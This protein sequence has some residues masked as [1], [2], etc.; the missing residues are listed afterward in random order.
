MNSYRYFSVNVAADA[1]AEV[2]I[3]HPPMNSLNYEVYHELSLLLEELESDPA[4]GAV[5]FGSNHPK[6][7]I[8]GA[9]IKD[10]EGYDRRS[11]AVSRKVD[12]VQ[13]VFQRLQRFPKPTVAAITGHALGG[14]CEFSLCVDF[15]VM[16]EGPARIGQPEVALGII[17]GGGGTQRL[18]R[19]IGRA[20]ATE[21]LMLSSRLS[22]NEAKA[23]GLVSRVGETDEDTREIAR[24]LAK[25]LAARAPLAIR[26]IKRAMNEGVDGDLVNGLAIE[27][28]EVIEVLDTA[29]ARE[30]VQAFLDKRDPNWEGR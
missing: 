14:G 22:A 17:P 27:R 4:V 23:V 25:H 20:A 13:G 7:F 1:V 29:D 16:T 26:A 10:M 15:R 3:D 5:L 24:D 18:P 2:I 6:V 30:G 19:L 9:D 8:S 28:A 11:G 12:T 21:M